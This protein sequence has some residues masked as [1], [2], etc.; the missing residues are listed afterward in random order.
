MERRPRCLVPFQDCNKSA[1]GDCLSAFKNVLITDDD[2]DDDD[3]DDYG[4][5]DD[6]DDDYDDDQDH[7]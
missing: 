6:D 3:D 2:D 7:K 1:L 4:D 5:D